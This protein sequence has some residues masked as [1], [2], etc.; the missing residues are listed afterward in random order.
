MI[1]TRLV[2]AMLVG[3]RRSGEGWVGVSRLGAGMWGGMGW[4][5]ET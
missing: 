1:L 5:G 4:G 2:V 3:L